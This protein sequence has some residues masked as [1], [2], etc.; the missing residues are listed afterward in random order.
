[1]VDSPHRPPAFL[2][3]AHGQVAVQPGRC[4]ESY[5]QLRM[6]PLG[7]YR[8]LGLPISELGGTIIDLEDVFGRAARQL[9]DAVRES[10][11][12][13]Q[14]FGLVDRFLR[15]AADRGP[16]PSPEVR[17]AQE[18]LTGDPRVRVGQVAAE[19]GWSHKHLITRFTQQVG[20]TPK[21][22]A[23]L[24]RFEQVMGQVR[25]ARVMDW[26][27]VAA[28][29]GYADQAHL[30]RE[31]R[32]FCGSTPAGYGNRHPVAEAAG[33]PGEFRSMR[34]AARRLPSF[35]PAQTRTGG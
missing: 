29:T 3:G 16:R 25:T 22:V 9:L 7:A 19:V 6:A 24:A 4:A 23:R 18:R 20:L 21:T 5:L 32:A 30:I 11:S 35:G 2:L 13:E 34:P 12:W 8:L 33:D 15:A 28:D 14:R 10:P 31:F 1:M 27:Q 17:H 26:G